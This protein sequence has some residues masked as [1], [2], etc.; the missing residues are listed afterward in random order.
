MAKPNAHNLV[1]EPPNAHM[2][3]FWWQSQPNELNLALA[4]SYSYR[5]G[6]EDV[7]YSDGLAQV[8]V[9]NVPMHGAMNDRGI[10]TTYYTVNFGEALEVQ[11]VLLVFPENAGMV[12]R[13]IHEKEGQ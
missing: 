12:E 11:E 3:S 8:Y 10:T 7:R 9:N 5:P 2:G 6:I 1:G 13:V 4:G